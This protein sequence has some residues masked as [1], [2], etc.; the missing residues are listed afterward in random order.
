MKKVFAILAIVLAVVIGTYFADKATRVK[1]T[2]HSSLNP[3]T[4]S[5]G[6][7]APAI[8]LKDLDGKD[9][10]LSQYKGQ[11]VLVNFWATW[12]APCREEIPE[13]IAMQRKYGP[14]G[15]TVLGIAMDEEGES[16]VAPFVQK[17]RFAVE[18]QASPMSYPILLG[19]DAA[20]EKFGGLLGYPTSVLISRDGK[21]IQ[22]IT[23]QINGEDVAKA[24]E[25]QL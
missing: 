5:L 7:P 8:S 10:A 14:K 20:A 18:G 25:A 2:H 22:H 15:F 17:E 9:V 19:N 13:L 12:C 16:V 24:I 3:D 6:K 11:V 21:Q 1:G 23:G 4:A